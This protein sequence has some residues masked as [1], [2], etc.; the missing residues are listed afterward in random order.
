MTALL[1]AILTRI[2]RVRE[3]HA[4]IDYAWAQANAPEL[5]D[6]KLAALYK[7]KRNRIHAAR[8][9]LPRINW[10][11]LIVAACVIGA[12]PLLVRDIAVKVLS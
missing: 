9:R 6:R 3:Q 2:A 4:R 11:R 10:D 5:A 7:A 1:R 12:G 8:F